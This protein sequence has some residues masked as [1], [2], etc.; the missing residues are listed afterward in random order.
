MPSE[1]DAE[2]SFCPAKAALNLLNQR[3]TLHIVFTLSQGSQR[4]N[5][6]GRLCSI[7]PRTLAFRLKEL[8][9]QGIVVRQVV[10]EAPSRVD[11]SLSEKGLELSHLLFSIGEWGRKWILCP[12]KSH[13]TTS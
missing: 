3:W 12:E 13:A 2:E 11:Y 5:E 9:Q 1:F 8:E 7:N 4:F 10:S 6:L